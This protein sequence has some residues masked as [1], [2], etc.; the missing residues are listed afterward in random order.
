MT[1]LGFQINKDEIF[2]ILAAAREIVKKRK[3]NSYLI[4][5][6]A[7]Y[8]DFE[9]FENHEKFCNVVVIGLA[10]KKFDYKHEAF[11]LNGSKLIAIHEGR[12]SK[13]P[14]GFQLLDQ[15]IL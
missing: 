12:Y 15:V 3:L 11:R 6:N 14:D 13:R 9:D 10:P 5:D 7:A 4:V 1:K 8:K 2:S